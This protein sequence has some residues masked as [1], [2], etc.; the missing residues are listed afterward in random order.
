MET[1]HVAASDTSKESAAKMDES[2]SA[3]RQNDCVASRLSDIGTVGATSEEMKT[4]L[5]AN[6]FPH[7]H[8]ASVSSRLLHLAAQGVI[9]Q[10]ERKRKSERSGRSQHVFVHKK[11]LAPDDVVID[12]A[13]KTDVKNHMPLATHLLKLIRDK[14]NWHGDMYSLTLTMDE[15]FKINRLARD[16]GL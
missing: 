7:V 3:K 16:V 15:V 11:H 10:V 12:N 14:G 6:G 8:N 2:G 5:H 1:M 13:R 4:F 9:C